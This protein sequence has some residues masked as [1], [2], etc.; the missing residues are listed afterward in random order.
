MLANRDL[1]TLR[2]GPSS[3]SANL[4]VNT[5]GEAASVVR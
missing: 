1:D 4:G 3:L 2:S 5:L